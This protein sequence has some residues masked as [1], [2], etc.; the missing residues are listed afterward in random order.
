MIHL[1]LSDNLDI[2]T[3]NARVTFTANYTRSTPEITASLRP[4]RARAIKNCPTFP[5]R[6]R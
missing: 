1:F 6:K 2:R 4:R 3:K 5:K